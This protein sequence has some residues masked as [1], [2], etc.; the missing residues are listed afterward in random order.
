MTRVNPANVPAL[1]SVF[2]RVVRHLLEQGE[3][4]MFPQYQ[5]CAYRGAHGLRCAVGVLINDAH[6]SH[7]L[8]GIGAAE[9]SVRDALVASG[10]PWSDDMADLLE[11]VQGIHDD[12][13]PDQ[14]A[15]RLE[16]VAADFGLDYP[17]QTSDDL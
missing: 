1:Q 15:D 5:T 10:V 8:E 6:Y 11:R 2:S 13:D 4:S 7:G 12:E 17:D 14:W 9:P 3:Q 16:R